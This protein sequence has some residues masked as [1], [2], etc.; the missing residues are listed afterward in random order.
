MPTLHTGLEVAT[1][2]DDWRLECLAMHLLRTC[3]TDELVAY[4]QAAEA[5]GGR[6]LAG[7]RERL[8]SIKAAQRAQRQAD[9][10]RNA[11]APAPAAF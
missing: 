2:S 3:T 11:P 8:T 9:T 7:L 1:D 5:K 6:R 10:T 4:L